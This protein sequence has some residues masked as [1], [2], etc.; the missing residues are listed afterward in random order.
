MTDEEHFDD[1]YHFDDSDAMGE[2]AGDKEPEV[3]EKPNYA[4]LIKNTM[5]NNNVLRNSLFT[6]GLILLA[7][8]V[9]KLSGHI[10]SR[11]KPVQSIAKIPMTQVKK[12]P[13]VSGLKAFN[14]SAVKPQEDTL[15]NTATQ[16]IEKKLS[17]VEQNQNNLQSEVATINNQVTGVNNNINNVMTKMSELTQVIEQLRA[18]VQE[19]SLEITKLNTIKASYR[20][21]DR[22]HHARNSSIRLKYYLEAVIPGRAWLIGNNGAT[23]T[24]RDGSLISG[25][26]VVRYIDAVQGRVLTSSG[27]VIRFNQEDS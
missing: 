23:L 4:H 19:Q 24:V 10:T 9:Y 21:R 14:S 16:E 13:V 25:Y 17:V 7:V 15:T 22:V 27:K 3:V 12:A 2:P 8:I 20:H 11:N 5:K 1:E 26:G 18:T 6:L